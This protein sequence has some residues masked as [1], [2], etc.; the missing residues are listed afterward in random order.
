MKLPIEKPLFS[1]F[2]HHTAILATLAPRSGWK[3]WFFRNYLQLM[4]FMNADGYM[5]MDTYSCI[6]TLS[7]CPWVTLD[8]IS[9]PQIK[10]QGEL[11]GMLQEHVDQGNYIYVGIDGYFISAYSAY[12]NFHMPHPILIYG[13]DA[14]KQ[15]FYAADFF[16]DMG[17]SFAE[18][19]WGELQLAFNR[20]GDEE[21]FGYTINVLSMKEHAEAYTDSS[22]ELRE[23]SQ[24]LRDYVS[25][26]IT[27][28]Y[29]LNVQI[30]LNSSSSMTTGEHWINSHPD[31]VWFGMDVYDRFLRDLQWFQ[32]GLRYIDY[33]NFS[34]L[35]HHKKLLSALYQHLH[36]E[37]FIEQDLDVTSQLKQIEK[38]ALLAR[39]AIIKY[40]IGGTTEKP[41][42]TQAT[43]HLRELAAQEKTLLPRLVHQLDHSLYANKN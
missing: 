9:R 17:F 33:R 23:I 11:I 41:L 29:K 39:N 14:E 26:R 27:A 1:T 40:V 21:P 34:T 3:P 43:G 5:T 28:D 24:I 16:T 8:S 36:E 37:R 18:V 31:E 22:T 15:I 30:P 2:A 7:S 6:Y 42:I 4:G 35:L 20:L 12:G 38:H 10:Q 25:A 19:G 13:Y 32:E